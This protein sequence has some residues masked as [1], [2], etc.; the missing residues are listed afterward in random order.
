MSK[1]M[2]K[3]CA[4]ALLLLLIVAVLMGYWRSNMNSLSRFSR[5]IESELEE[6]SLTIYYR[7]FFRLSRPVALYQL[8]GGWYD[9]T[10]RLMDGWYDYKVVIDGEELVMHRELLIQLANIELV[11]VRKESREHARLY[12]VFEHARHG[13][14]FSF[15]FSGTVADAVFV[16]GRLVEDNRIFYEVVLPFLPESAAEIIQSGIDTS[17]PVE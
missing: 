5:F 17:W 12:Y 3:I 1:K 7:D 16:N 14:I 11:P 9:E 15:L 4:S 2:F 6:I 10:G 8:V 13:E